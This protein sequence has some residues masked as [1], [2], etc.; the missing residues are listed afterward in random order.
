MW[1]S[2]SIFILKTGSIALKNNTPQ[3]LNAGIDVGR[4]VALVAQMGNIA[5]PYRRKGIWDN[6]KQQFG[7]SSA[8]KFITPEYH[9][10]YAL[11]KY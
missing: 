11:P 10:G 3:K 7:T 2:D 4:D 6:A 5:F 8:N 9:N 1:V